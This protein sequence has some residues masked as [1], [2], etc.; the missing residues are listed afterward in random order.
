M[1]LPALNPHRPGSL[2]LGLAAVLLLLADPPAAAAT[3]DPETPAPP[4]LRVI[5]E[6]DAGGDP[7]DEQSLVRFLL[8]SNEWDVEGILANRPKAR[9]RENLNPARTGLGVVQRLLEAYA[10]CYPN[11]SRYDSRYPH[12][13]LLRRRTVAGYDD[14]RQGVDLL[15]QALERDD[16]RP[17]WYSDW[18]SDRGSATNNLRRALDAV[19]ATRGPETYATLK[20]RLRLTSGDAFGDHTDRIAPPFILRADTWRPEL[21]GRRWYHRFSALTSQ[22]GGFDLV[23]D[24]L[25]GH[26]P[27]GALYPTNTTHWAKEGDSLSFL[28]LVPNGLNAPEH[29]GWGG[30]GG[31][32]ALAP[33]PAPTAGLETKARHYEARVA[34]QWNG[35]AHRDHTLARWAADLQND[36]KARLDACLPPPASPNHPPTVRL[37]LGNRGSSLRNPPP[38]RG[39]EYPDDFHGGALLRLHPGSTVEV[40]TTR[41]TDPDGQALQTE[42]FPYPEAGT[43]STP[44]PAQVEGSRLRLTAPHVVAPTVWHWIA[45]VTDDGRPALSR[46]R[47]LVIL[48]EPQPAPQPQPAA[49]DRLETAFAPPPGLATSPEPYATLLRFTDGRAVRSSL[50]WAER[51]RELL[52]EWQTLL[53]PWP[54]VPEHPACEVL[55]REIREGIEFR[56]VRVETGP[57]QRAEGWLLVP[58]VGA[59][60]PFP[61]VFVP[62]YEPETSTGTGRPGRDYALQLARRGFVTLALGSPGGDARR[63]DTRSTPCQPLAYLAAV[64]DHAARVLE[65]L[66]EVDPRRLGIVGH[67]YGGKWA[68]FGAAF[69]DRYAAAAF[70]DPGIVWDESRPNVNYWDPWYLG[71]VF[72]ADGTSA[73][74]RPPGLPSASHPRTGAYAELVRGGHDLHELLALLAPRPFLV[75]GGSED[76]P[77]RWSALRPVVEVNALLGWSNRVAYTSRPTHDPTPESNAQ[78]VA[79]FEAHLGDP[80]P[81]PQLP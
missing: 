81:T 71:R 5:I 52:Q 43:A 34:D 36:F 51:R 77:T 54:I 42:W 19:R 41:S 61:A 22:A 18:G 73:P 32:L 78:I 60:G 72:R 27:L 16:P 6:T 10:A 11:L 9:D 33:Q 8:L 15:I 3:L 63:P 47:R 12:P 23:R 55:R 31:R 39:L 64:A 1:G 74:D 66:P 29:P 53:G 59:P 70:S 76:P 50:D 57:G 25:P 49:L 13:D 75:S 7:D 24:V 62:F 58:G 4:R 38:P 17:V 44:I 26:G 20:G 67:S 48:V 30:W 40:T 14:S 37:T 80:P 45:R 21:E 28:Y 65:S 56:R 69:C 79:F 35:T 68:L 46:Y 2:A